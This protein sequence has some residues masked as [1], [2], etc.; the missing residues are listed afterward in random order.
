MELEGGDQ[1]I[2]VRDDAADADLAKHHLTGETLRHLKKA[3]DGHTILIP[4][5]SND[6][7]DPLNWLPSKKWA[8]LLAISVASM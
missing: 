7:R 2:I 5:P 6:P 4:Q 8:V 1:E 3:A